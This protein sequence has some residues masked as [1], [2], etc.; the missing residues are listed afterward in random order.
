MQ[1]CV[2]A[3]DCIAHIPEHLQDE[4]VWHPEVGLL[5]HLQQ[6]SWA[7]VQQQEAISL[8]AWWSCTV[9][10]QKGRGTLQSGYYR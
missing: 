8:V 5:H 10:E 7:E 4:S 6:S 9:M 3:V 2:H 1:A